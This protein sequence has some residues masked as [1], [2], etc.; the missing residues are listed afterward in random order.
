MLTTVV[1]RSRGRI[2]ILDIGLKTLSSDS[3]TLVVKNKEDAKMLEPSEEDWN[4]DIGEVTDIKPATESK[5]FQVMF[6]QQ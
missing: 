2:A 6:V 1:I 4:I 5:L 3:G